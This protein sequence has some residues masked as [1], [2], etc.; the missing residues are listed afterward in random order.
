MFVW[1]FLY[2]IVKKSM[3][4]NVKRVYEAHGK[5]DG[6]RILIDRLWP[7]GISKE[8]ARIDVWAKEITP[9]QELR[10][11]YHAD[12]AKRYPEFKKKYRIELAS[13]KEYARTFLAPYKKATLVTAVRDIDHSHVPVLQEFLARL[14]TTK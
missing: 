11:W 1:H 8:V 5:T 14:I 3:E 6:A 12:P 13:Q 4:L 10:R 7:R 9:S 2:T